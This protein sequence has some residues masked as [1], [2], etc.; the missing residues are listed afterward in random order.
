M[1]I[2]CVKLHGCEN[3]YY[4]V[5]VRYKTKNYPNKL[6][7]HG[8]TQKLVAIK[9]NRLPVIFIVLHTYNWYQAFTF[10]AQGN[11]AL[12]RSF[13][14]ACWVG[15]QVLQYFFLFL[16]W[17]FSLG[18]SAKHGGSRYLKKGLSFT[19]GQLMTVDN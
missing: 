10:N 9:M 3:Y 6:S 13:S 19:E 8:K 11:L 18:S 7:A 4:T 2:N 12:H 15:R 14:L 17:T 5:Q 16:F 1:K